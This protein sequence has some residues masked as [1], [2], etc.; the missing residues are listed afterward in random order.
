MEQF[1]GKKAVR[2]APVSLGRGLLD[3][4][5]IGSPVEILKIKDDVIYY[6]SRHGDVFN[7]DPRWN[8]DKWRL[9]DPPEIAD[10]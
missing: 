3:Y 2:I 9:W 6:K 1:V 4:S 10:V 8:D 7:L 5:F